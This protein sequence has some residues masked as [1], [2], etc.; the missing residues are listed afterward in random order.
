VSPER[1]AEAAAAALPDAFGRLERLVAIPSVSAPGADPAP[2][3]RAAEAV[4]DWARH[5]GF[6]VASVLE[7]AGALP[8]AWALHEGEPGAPVVLL[9]AHHDVVP[10]GDED[11]GWRTPPFEATVRDGRMWGRGTADDKSAI[12]VHLTAAAA[13]LASPSPLTLMLFV[14]G[15]E[16][17]SS[18]NA[19]RL[20]HAAPGWREPDVVLVPDADAWS[21]D[22]PYLTTA[23]RGGIHVTVTVTALAEPVHSGMYGGVVPSAMT[24][25]LA[26]LA[27]LVDGDG[28]VAVPGLLVDPPDAAWHAPPEAELLASAGAVAGL[29]A[30]GRDTVA[31]RLYAAPAI[32]VVG[33]DTPRPEDATGQLSARVRARLDVRI[34]PTQDPREAAAALRA[35]LTAATPWGARV[36]V[37]ILDPRGG[38]RLQEQSP[39]LA[40]AETALAEAWGAPVER[41][42]S[43]AS[44]PLVGE[45]AGHC[46]G[47]AF[48]LTAV[49]DALCNAHGPNESVSLALV[50]RLAV[51]HALLLDR[52]GG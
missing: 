24:C 16:E 51:A 1:V 42:G 27:G 28:A 49:A 17:I 10:A 35:R 9:Y 22:V 19:W 44:I 13:L 30:L 45:L 43:G 36:E 26:L 25:M 8:A 20:L 31:R 33:L 32:T 46:P 40:L 2:V 41:I 34:A 37:E 11:A 15:E 21:V 38:Y 48:V 29:R 18:P 39:V 3:R 6:P 5:A 14:E 50:E 7:A 12:A 47:A 4:C 52:L 23:L